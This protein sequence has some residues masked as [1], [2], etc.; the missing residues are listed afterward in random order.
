MF[1]L[2]EL[3]IIPLLLLGAAILLLVKIFNI[4]L[5]SFKISLNFKEYYLGH[6]LKSAKQRLNIIKNNHDLSNLLTELRMLFIFPS[7][8]GLKPSFVEDIQKHHL[9]IVNFILDI[10]SKKQED[11]HL[12][13]RLEEETT[14]QYELLREAVS[15]QIKNER[16]GNAKSG[17]WVKQ[18]IKIRMNEI[19]ESLSENRKNFKIILK[20][21]SNL[22]LKN[23]QKDEYAYH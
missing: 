1:N 4:Y 15:L 5:T 22:D 21:L 19:N 18:S 9:E 2:L 23:K 13:E 10:S 3:W 12:I 14:K 11:L 7:L 16:L 20:D 8:S 17:A 6:S